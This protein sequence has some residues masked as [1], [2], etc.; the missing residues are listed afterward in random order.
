ML[1]GG[2]QQLLLG[3][4]VGHR[5]GRRDLRIDSGSAHN[6]LRRLGGHSRHKDLSVA[7]AIDLLPAADGTGASGTTQLGQDGE[8]L[9][10]TDRA[11]GEANG[12]NAN[13]PTKGRLLH[14]SE[15]AMLQQHEGPFQA[16]QVYN[17]T[18]QYQALTQAINE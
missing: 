5:S 17:E 18:H 13:L 8:I 2:C 4:R 14:A 3:R 9:W 1:G 16:R 6:V 10:Q 7:R 12:D 15:E 11:T